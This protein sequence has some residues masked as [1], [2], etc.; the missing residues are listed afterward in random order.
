MLGLLL[1]LAEVYWESLYFLCQS[2]I[3]WK[4]SLIP[5]TPGLGCFDWFGWDKGGGGGGGGQL[6]RWNRS[7]V[8]LADADSMGKQLELLDGMVVV[9]A[10]DPK[11]RMSAGNEVGADAEGCSRKMPAGNSA[12]WGGK[13]TTDEA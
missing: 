1:G 6:A 8:G 9:W 5:P 12:P 3:D 13:C 7:A 2:H 4:G 11:F 10:A